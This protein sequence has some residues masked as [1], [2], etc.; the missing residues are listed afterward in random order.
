MKAYDIMSIDIEAAKEN[1]T[2]SEIGTRL[3]LR[4]INGMPIIDDDG[5]VVGILTI[6][7]ILR[8]IKDKKD[9]DMLKAGD[10]MTKNPIVI[11]QDTDMMDMIDIMDKKGVEMIPVVDEEK[12]GRLIGVVSRKDIIEEKFN[13]RFVTIGMK[14]TI[15]KT[16]GQ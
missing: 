12:D 3:I 10:I 16:L 8:A 2:V 6:I 15:T 11:E 1:A 4:S 14:K 7:D 13:E 5:K 9:I